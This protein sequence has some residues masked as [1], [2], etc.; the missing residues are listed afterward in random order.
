[1]GKPGNP[2]PPEAIDRKAFILGMITAFAECVANECKKIA[3]SPPF[4]PA[5]Y[6]YVAAEA[7]IIAGE[8]GVHL[9]F[10]PSLDLP[11]DRRLNWLVIYK[12][13][14]VLDEYRALRSRGHNPALDLDIFRGLLSYG[15]AWGESADKVVDRMREKRPTT[16]PFARILLRPGDWPVPAGKPTT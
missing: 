5:D 6:D 3:F 7:E 10:E 1:M 8:L 13:Q 12:Y 11:D 2:I 15:T 4:Y 14:D 9:W 16:D